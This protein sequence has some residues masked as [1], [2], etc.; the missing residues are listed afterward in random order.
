MGADSNTVELME[1]GFK[2][3]GL[4]IDSYK[5]EEVQYK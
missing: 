4:I 5:D 1:M 3:K 2:N